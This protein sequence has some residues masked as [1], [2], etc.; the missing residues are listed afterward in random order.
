MPPIDQNIVLS[1]AYDFKTFF[2]K[3]KLF[4]FLIVTTLMLLLQ[5]FSTLM[6]YLTP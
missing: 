1:T 3:L 4:K 5:E 2:N 6:T